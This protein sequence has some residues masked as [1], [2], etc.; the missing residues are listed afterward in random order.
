[1]NSAIILAAG[2]GRRMQTE[3]SKQYLEV[4]NKPLLLY[5]LEVFEECKH[6]DEILLVIS[7]DELDYCMK[8]IVENRLWHKKIR[9]VLG[10]QERQHSV[11]NALSQ[12]KEADFVLIHDGARPLV[13]NKIIEDCI[14][15]VVK[16]GAVSCGMP[17]K[18]TIKVVNKEGFINYTPNRDS[19]WITQTPQAFDLGLI[20][21]AHSM[22]VEEN[23]V[24][25]DDAMLVEVLGIKVKMVEGSY[26]NIKVTTPDDLIIFENILKNRI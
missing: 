18:D 11:R 6:I 24:A 14:K 5:T 15:D 16:Y 9:T 8:N 10:G 7:E 2:R 23:I 12:I 4:L 3:K 26:E 17:V 20:K 19:I 22:A 1:M 21:R 13:T 25:T